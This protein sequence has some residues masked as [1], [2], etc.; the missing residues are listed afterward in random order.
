VNEE[1]PRRTV[2]S[3]SNNFLTMMHPVSPPPPAG[4]GA[5]D[6]DHNEALSSSIPPCPSRFMP[7]FFGRNLHT[8]AALLSWCCRVAA[9]DDDDLCSRLASAAGAQSFQI[10]RTT[11]EIKCVMFG[12]SEYIVCAFHCSPTVV[13]HNGGD[14]TMVPFAPPLCLPADQNAGVLHTQYARDRLPNSVYGLVQT[15]PWIQRCV[16]GTA[17]W[18]MDDLLLMHRTFWRATHGDCTS[19]PPIKKRPIVLCGHGEGGAVAQAFALAWQTGLL[20]GNCFTFGSTRTGNTAMAKAAADSVPQEMYHVLNAADSVVLTPEPGAKAAGVRLY[21]PFL[22][23]AKGRI[24]ME[25]STWAR[26]WDQLCAHTFFTLRRVD[27]SEHQH[28]LRTYHAA[29]TR[30]LPQKKQGKTK[31]K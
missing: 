15:W 20:V 30:P 11:H 5:N 26:R 8:R 25:P 14:F 23:P 4:A 10:T 16:V 17:G 12:L 6:D 2:L 19:V 28:A 1:A 3:L 21:I 27:A 29:L 13:H 18:I 24:T 9:D 22:H 31:R 7:D